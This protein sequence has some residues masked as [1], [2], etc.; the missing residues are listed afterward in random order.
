VKSTV[1]ADQVDQVDADQEII[2]RVLAGERDAFS[3]LIHRYSD[4]LFRH[5]LGMTGSPDVAEDIL[6][7]SFIK[8]YSHLARCEDD[9]MPGSFAS[10]PTGA[11]TG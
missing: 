8:A 6:Q 1:P 10:W 4:P 9:S 11:R 3:L 5:A 2:A 7:M